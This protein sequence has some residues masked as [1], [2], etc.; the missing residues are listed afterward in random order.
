[1]SAFPA[2]PKQNIMPHEAACQ[3]GSSAGSQI[4]RKVIKHS[5]FSHISSASW[6]ERPRRR[7]LIAL[8]WR[9]G[10]G[11]LVQDLRGEMTSEI[12]SSSSRSMAKV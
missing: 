9:F 4:Y 7:R 6:W 1:M 8:T 11:L 3:R 12:L 10:H 5:R 2:P